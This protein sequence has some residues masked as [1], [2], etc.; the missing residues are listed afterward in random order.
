MSVPR[1]GPAPIPARASAVRSTFCRRSLP[2]LR[3]FRGTRSRSKEKSITEQ[4]VAA[5]GTSAED[6]ILRIVAEVLKAPQVTAEDSLYDFG[7][8]SLQAMRIC[9]RIRKE[10]GWRISPKVLFESETLADVISATVA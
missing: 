4:P 5:S 8:T 2:R 1:C 7:G 10:L 9:V 6:A 3:A